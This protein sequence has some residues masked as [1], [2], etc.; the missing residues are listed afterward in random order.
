[1]K[2][3]KPADWV[4]TGKYLSLVTGLGFTMVASVWLGWLLGSWLQNLLG[5]IAW[6]VLGLVIGIASGSVA[7][8]TMLKK[9]ISW[10]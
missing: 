7:V 3:M 6:M 2:L 10:E 9:I 8:Y 4:R 5:G 1:M